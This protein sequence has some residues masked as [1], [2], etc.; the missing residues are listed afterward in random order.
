MSKLT[1]PNCSAEMN[2]HAFKVEYDTEN[3]TITDPDYDGVLKEA[4]YCPHC[5]HSELV[6]AGR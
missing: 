1:C 2:R 4:H 5:G 3:P 6:T